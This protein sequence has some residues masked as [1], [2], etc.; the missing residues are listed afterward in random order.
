LRISGLKAKKQNQDEYY[1][2]HVMVFG[3]SPPADVAVAN[4]QNASCF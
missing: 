2:L 4:I 3:I 1:S